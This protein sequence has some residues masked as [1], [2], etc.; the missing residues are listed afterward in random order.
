MITHFEAPDPAATYFT[1]M[2]Q[3][4]AT[5]LLTVDSTECAF[6]PL[7]LLFSPEY[8]KANRALYQSSFQ[9]HGGQLCSTC[10]C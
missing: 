9:Q 8:L 6:W 10:S 5:G 3:D 4:P 1:K 2:T 7:L